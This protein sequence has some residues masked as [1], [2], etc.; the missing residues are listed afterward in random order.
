MTT[1]VAFVC[2]QNAGRSQMS[3]AF[4]ERE[5]ERR[6][7]DDAVEIRTGGTRPAERVHDVVVEVMREAGFDLSDR[8]PRE[9]STAELESCDYVAT[10]GCSTLELDTD[11]SD[12]DVRDWALDDPDGKDLERVREIRDEI[13]DRVSALFDEIERELAADA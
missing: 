11:D 9:V 5:R 12:V 2:V 8:T 7:L 10:M 1:T 4:A 6:E 3:T 13:G